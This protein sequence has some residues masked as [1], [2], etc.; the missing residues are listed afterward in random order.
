M[1][2]LALPRIKVLLFYDMTKFSAIKNIM[3]F[4]QVVKN[5]DASRLFSAT[6]IVCVVVKIFC[7]CEVSF[8][9]ITINSSLCPALS[10]NS[11]SL[12]FLLPCRGDLLLTFRDT[13]GAL[14]FCHPRSASIVDTPL[15]VHPCD[16]WEFYSR[17]IL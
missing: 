5:K 11:P 3:S 12:R 2:F 6:C 9:S 8:F 17:A 13:C 7:N 1:P 14:C 10:A 15:C 16:L 4:L